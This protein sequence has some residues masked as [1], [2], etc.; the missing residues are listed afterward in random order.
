MNTNFEPCIWWQE[1]TCSEEPLVKCVG[2]GSI[3]VL[4]KSQRKCWGTVERRT[5]ED[6]SRC[7]LQCGH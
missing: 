3:S 7:F 2:S 5:S 6:S 4:L 1:L